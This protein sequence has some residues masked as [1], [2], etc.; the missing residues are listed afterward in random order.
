M[1]GAAQ[2]A[3][4]IH[5]AGVILWIGPTVAG[6]HFLVLARRRS[7]EEGVEVSSLEAW[8]QERF[9]W[10]VNLEHLGFVLMVGGGLARAWSIGLDSPVL[11]WQVPWLRAKVLLV[12][13]LFVPIEIADVWITNIVLGRALAASG[14][15]GRL[16]PALALQRTFHRIAVPLLA[17]GIPLALYLAVVRPV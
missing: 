5:L 8:V 7:I 9:V 1:P 10:L 16:A 17:A 15:T 4:L 13:L 14:P 11:L 3:L 2:F 12:L 6:W